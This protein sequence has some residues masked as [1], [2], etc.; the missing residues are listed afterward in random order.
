MRGEKRHAV[1]N[2]PPPPARARGGLMETPQPPSHGYG[3]AQFDGA[4]YPYAHPDIREDDEYEAP[5]DSD[6]S[7]LSVS[8]DE[9]GPGT[10]RARGRSGDACA[11]ALVAD[12][13]RALLLSLLL[14]F[15]WLMLVG[16][17]LPHPWWQ[18]A[19]RCPILQVPRRLQEA[20]EAENVQEVLVFLTARRHEVR[21]RDIG[22]GGRRC[23]GSRR[24]APR[25]AVSLQTV[26][27][28][29]LSHSPP[30][31]APCQVLPPHQLS[32]RFPAARRCCRFAFD[33]VE[34]A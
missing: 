17:G 32:R 1:R 2:P 31:N 28:A 20:E 19:R 13:M 29:A 4:R 23:K 33:P 26:L 30:V 18:Q 24:V 9:A 25:R 6:L 8:G 12:D 3:A 22:R 16:S 34:A 15:W 11:S 27:S 14:L 10:P 5:T 21:G 7:V